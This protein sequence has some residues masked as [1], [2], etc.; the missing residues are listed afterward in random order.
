MTAIQK[1]FQKKGVGFYLA[2]P[3]FVF[4]LLALIYYNKTGVTEFNPTLSKS[5]IACLWISMGLTLVSL[6][7]DFKPV[8][9]LAY[10]VCLYG[11]FG[12]IASQATFIVNVFVAI[13]GNTFGSGFIATVVFFVLAFVLMLL[14]G[15]LTNWKP[16]AKKVKEGE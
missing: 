12:Y 16:W 14:S 7:L 13:D 4:A 6:A 3:A 10:L 11:F 15:I 1:F 5:A 9:Y 2:I 8:R